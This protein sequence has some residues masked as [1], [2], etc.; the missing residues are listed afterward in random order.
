[1]TTKVNNREGESENIKHVRLRLEVTDDSLK[2]NSHL[3]TSCLRKLEEFITPE[4]LKHS[5]L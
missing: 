4:N 5:I 3:T 1:M 2:A